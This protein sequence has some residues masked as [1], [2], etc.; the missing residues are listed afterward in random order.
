[1]FAPHAIAQPQK[2]RR[3]VEV[4]QETAQRLST[5]SNFKWT[6]MGACVC[7][8]IAQTITEL[9]PAEIH[10]RALQ[11]AGDWSEQA[12]EYCPTSQLPIDHIIDKMMD[13]GLRRQDIG[14]LERLSD[15][16]ILRSFPPEQRNLSHYRKADVIRYLQRYS[17]LLEN[18]LN[19]A[20]ISTAIP[21]GPEVADSITARGL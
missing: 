2:L 6:H 10:A 13:L 11:K 14:H 20:T 15:P 4:L 18:R 1:M 21:A 5:G 9:S 19:Q 17:E 12:R 3:L 7:G 8:H 16:T